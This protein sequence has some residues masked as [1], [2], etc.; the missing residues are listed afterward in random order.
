MTFEEVGKSIKRTTELLN[1][2]NENLNLYKIWVGEDIFFVMAK[3]QLK[4]LKILTKEVDD[5]MDEDDIE[6]Q[7]IGIDCDFVNFKQIKKGE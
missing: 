2:L 1:S 3:S 7:F 4:A 6:I 5:I